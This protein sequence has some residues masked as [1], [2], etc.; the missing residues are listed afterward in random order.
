MA[1]PREHILANLEQLYREA[2]QRASEGGDAGEMARLDFGFRRDQLYLE[3][4]L[5]VRDALSAMPS[6]GAPA[7]PAEAPEKS[8]MEHIQDIRS[9][10]RFPFGR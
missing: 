4:V 1:R 2:Y 7:G 8:V 9:L 3:A 10:A 5:D 6:S